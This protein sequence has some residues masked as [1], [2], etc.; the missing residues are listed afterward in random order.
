MVFKLVLH[1]GWEH[2][3]F[4]STQTRDA[5]AL[6]TAQIAADAIKSAPRR[7]ATKNNWNQIKKH[8]E[9]HVELDA[10]GW[11]G[12]VT[13]EENHRVRHAMLQERGWRDPKGRR[14]PGRRYLKG[15]L[16]RA[17]VD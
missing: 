9:A 11:H 3:I 5:V 4:S 15:A 12:N 8:I 10:Q 13:I 7:S 16:L 6:H 17:R 1:R 14:H 2:A